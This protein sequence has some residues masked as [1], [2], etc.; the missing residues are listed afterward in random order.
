MLLLR[1]GK[2]A[3]C[4]CCNAYHLAVVDVGCHMDDLESDVN[5]E[6]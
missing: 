4:D 1:V 6:K 2:V 3:F 5:K